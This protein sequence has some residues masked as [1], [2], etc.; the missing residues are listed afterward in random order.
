VTSDH[1]PVLLSDRVEVHDPRLDVVSGRDR[2]R[3][4][5]EPGQGRSALRI[6]PQR[7]PECVVAIGQGQ[8]T[9][10]AVVGELDLDLETEDALVPLPTRQQ[11]PDRQLHMMDLRE[12]R[13]TGLLR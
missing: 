7:Q 13:H 8:P 5:I 10:H 6:D 2:E 12:R 4:R 11:V 3:H 1:T 9:E